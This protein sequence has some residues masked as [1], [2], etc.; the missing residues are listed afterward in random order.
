MIPAES[1]SGPA[2]Y[3]CRGADGVVLVTPT[4]VKARL[5]FDALAVAGTSHP[6]GPADVAFRITIGS[7][8]GAKRFCGRLGGPP[9]T[10]NSPTLYK[11]A[12]APAP[13]DCS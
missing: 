9:A 5:D 8:H 1:P 7:G 13:P 11:R 4:G 10:K 12:A 3:R 2:G 6:Y